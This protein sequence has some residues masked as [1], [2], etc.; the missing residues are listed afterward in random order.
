MKRS[1]LIACS[2]CVINRTHSRYMQLVVTSP[3][4]LAHIVPVLRHFASFTMQHFLVIHQ[5]ASSDNTEEGSKRNRH[6]TVVVLFGISS[7]GQ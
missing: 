4:T 6:K 2:V 7:F 1:T 5:V 3:D